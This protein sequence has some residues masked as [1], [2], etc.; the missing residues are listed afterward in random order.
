[1]GLLD[2]VVDK[3]VEKYTKKE[4]IRIS[5]EQMA[6]IVREEFIK[7]ADEE[8]L[9]KVSK[10]AKGGGVITQK[11]LESKNER[12]TLHVGCIQ[13]GV[14]FGRRKVVWIQD[15]QANKFYQ[16]DKDRNWKKFYKAV[17]SDVKMER[18]NR[19]RL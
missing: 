8:F 12:Y 4:T 6:E 7:G 3:A 15:N 16:L 1:M 13:A 9:R 19:N 5:C 17:D 10:T 11:N 2:K 14:A 18:V